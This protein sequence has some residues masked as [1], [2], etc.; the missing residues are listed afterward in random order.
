MPPVGVPRILG[1]FSRCPNETAIIFV[2]T[3]KGAIIMFETAVQ[4]KRT[5]IPWG[6]IMGVAALAGLLGAGYM[7]IT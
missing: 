4:E 5:G 1:E 6:I 7:L 3:H 2:Y